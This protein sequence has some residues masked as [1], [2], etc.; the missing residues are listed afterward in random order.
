[1]KN[2]VE[3]ELEVQLVLSPEDSVPV[4]ALLSYRT[5]DP[6]AVHFTFHLGSDSPVHWVFSRELL[7]EGVFR[8]CGHGD[9]RV[10]PT[11]SGR[12]GLICLALS[13]PAGDALLEA[14][15]EPVAEWLEKAL[16][17]IPSGR[18]HQSLDLDRE[19]AEL[20]TEY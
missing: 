15:A 9:V 3:Q 14:P 10:W 8:A 13:S 11:R 2:V 4:P 19:L 17:L 12:R 6:Y 1:M 5:D 16:R 20:L 7:I 18:E